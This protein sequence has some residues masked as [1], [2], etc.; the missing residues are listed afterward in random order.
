MYAVIE[1]GTVVNV[2]VGEDAVVSPGQS[3]VPIS[4][5]RVMIGTNY[6]GNNFVF[7]E[8]SLSNYIDAKLADLKQYRKM[9]A[10]EGI[11]W[12]GNTYDTDKDSRSV[13]DTERTIALEETTAYSL[14]WKLGPNNY[15]TLNHTE[16][17]TLANNVR[18][19]VKECFRSE[20]IHAAQIAGLTSIANVDNYDFT[21]GWPTRDY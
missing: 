6:D 11:T 21:T 9:K 13:L 8:I 14:E 19:Y 7:S 10:K 4:D 15:I 5:D 2:V 16:T 1:N 12:G 18:D 17:V 20:G 3:L